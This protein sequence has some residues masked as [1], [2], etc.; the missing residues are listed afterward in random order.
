M[1]RANLSSN[2]NKMQEER[3]MKIQERKMSLIKAHEV[4]IKG[5]ECLNVF[6]DK[7]STVGDVF[8]AFWS[9]KKSRCKKQIENLFK[10]AKGEDPVAYI[11]CDDF[12]PYHFVTTLSKKLFVHPFN[13]YQG[14]SEYKRFGKK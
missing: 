5:I 6:D 4:D 7:E 3:M 9:Y 2:L 13:M 14:F 1:T 12:I 10:I 11:G 8:D